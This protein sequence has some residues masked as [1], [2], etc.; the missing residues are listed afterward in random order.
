MEE[1]KKMNKTITEKMNTLSIKPAM[2]KVP[3]VVFDFIKEAELPPPSGITALTIQ[4]DYRSL[5]GTFIFDTNTK[6]ILLHYPGRFKENGRVEPIYKEV[7][8]VQWTIN[9]VRDLKPLKEGPVPSGT[10]DEIIPFCCNRCV[11]QKSR[12]GGRRSRLSNENKFDMFIGKKGTVKCAFRVTKKISYG[13][14]L[15]QR[16]YTLTDGK[17]CETDGSGYEYQENG[18]KIL[19][20]PVHKTYYGLNLR[21]PV[22]LPNKHHAKPKNETEYG[23]IILQK[24]E[25]SLSTVER[26]KLQQQ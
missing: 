11:P 16:F 10:I 24:M 3:S 22:D 26:E 13:P 18:F 7:N 8:G 23:P 5:V 4:H 17:V 15:Y 20:C 12:Y 6:K 19:T 2:G 9:Y 21:H 1:Q 25:E 14:V